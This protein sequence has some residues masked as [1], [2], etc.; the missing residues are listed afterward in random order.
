MRPVRTW[1]PVV[2]IVSEIRE[3]RGEFFAYAVLPFGFMR[4]EP[5][6]TR[7]EAERAAPAVVAEFRSALES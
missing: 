2:E 4:S 6:A 3:S 7:E 5:F 1:S